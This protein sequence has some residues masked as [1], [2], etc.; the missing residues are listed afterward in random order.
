MHMCCQ[1]NSIRNKAIVR[2][3]QARHASAVAIGCFPAY[4]R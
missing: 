2:M 1:F 3:E 4:A